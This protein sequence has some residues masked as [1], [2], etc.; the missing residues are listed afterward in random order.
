MNLQ[1]DNLSI[2][3]TPPKKNRQVCIDSLNLTFAKGRFIAIIGPNGSGKST[4]LRSIIGIHN[5]I[6]GN[7]LLGDKNILN[8]RRRQRCQLIAYLPQ[9]VS[10]YSNLL[11]KQMV[12][13]GRMPEKGW[14]HSWSDNDYAI[15]KEVL[16]Q[17]GLPDHMNRHITT[18]SGGEL[19]RVYL[20]RML[21]TKARIYL[22]DEPT[23][24][25]DIKNTL[26]FLERC[27]SLCNRGA[28]IISTL[29]DLN[30]VQSYADDILCLSSKHNW[31]YGSKQDIFTRDILKKIFSIQIQMNQ[32]ILVSK[33]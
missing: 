5:D 31:Y 30:L 17:V 8:Y 3:I 2:F 23:N 28:T 9:K 4:L 1:I 16:D 14:I 18:L 12:V 7:I 20:A 21:M 19:Q 6:K 26:D 11:V 27:K 15:A 13:L 32:G 24:S 22:M 29:H 10:L 33:L 25:L